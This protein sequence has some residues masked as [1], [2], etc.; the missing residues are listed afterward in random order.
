MK[1]KKIKYIAV[2]FYFVLYELISIL[3]GK[4]LLLPSIGEI[5]KAFVFLSGEKIFWI[6][7]FFSLLRIFSGFL[8]AVLLGTVLALISYFTKFG[9]EFLKPLLTV[10]RSTPVVSFIILALL[11]IKSGY[12]PVFISFLMVLPIVWENIYEGLKNTDVKLLQMAEVFG[13]SKWKKIKYIYAFQCA[14]FF[15]TACITGLGFAWKSGIA[16][17]VICMPKFS[18]GRRLYESKAY[19]ETPQLFAWTLTVIILSIIAEKGIKL[20]F[21]SVQKGVR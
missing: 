21:D 7:V 9:Y 11:W 15:K 1:N 18:I 3:I 20:L 10:I 8:I 19:L 12:V 5:L 16:A 14:P 17:E 2:L 6:N 13:F 4:S